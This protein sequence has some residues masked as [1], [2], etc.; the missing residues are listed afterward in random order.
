MKVCGFGRRAASLTIDSSRRR[1]GE[2]M[3]G[4]VESYYYLKRIRISDLIDSQGDAG[5]GKQ[6][7][8]FD[9]ARHSVPP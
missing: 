6:G 3:D 1:G 2:L 5:R 4:I 7:G 9:P 8:P